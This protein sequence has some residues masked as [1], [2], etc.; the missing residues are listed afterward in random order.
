MHTFGKMFPNTSIFQ[1][2]KNA[3]PLLLFFGSGQIEKKKSV[4]NDNM[5]VLHREQCELNALCIKK[6]ELTLLL[7]QTF[8]REKSNTA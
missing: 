8:Y 4:I 2:E 1:S 3:K 5:M 7:K 6:L